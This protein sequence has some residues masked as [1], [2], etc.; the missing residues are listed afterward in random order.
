[1][2]KV[3]DVK[4]KMDGSLDKI[5]RFG[6]RQ[7][8]ELRQGGL[9][10]LRY[11]IALIFS[12]LGVAPLVPLVIALRPWVRIRFGELFS[13]RIGHFACNTE[14]YLCERDAGLHG[15]KT[16]D[17]FCH[18]HSISNQQLKRMWERTLQV[19]S[20]ARPLIKLFLILQQLAPKLQ[21][22]VIFIDSDRDINAFFSKTPPHLF[23]TLEEE[24]EGQRA[25]R[26]MGIPE[27]APFVCFH[28]RDSAYLEAIYPDFDTSYHDYRNSRIQ[29]L[30]PAMEELTRRGYYIVRMGVIV[31]ET[32]NTTNPMIIDYAN[33]YRSDFLDIYLGAKCRFFV[34]ST[35][36]I[37]AIPLIF[38]R[39][40]AVIN[41]IPLEY[42]PPSGAKTLVIPKRLWLRSEERYLTFREI[43]NSGVG[44]FL[45]YDEY[46]AKGIEVIE[47]TPQEITALV[48]EMDEGL[49]GTWQSDAGDE[50]R[51]RRFFSLFR[52]SKLNRILDTRVGAEFL[53]QNHDLLD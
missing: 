19:S 7:V 41:A 10:L 20:L 34:G 35:A 45:R 51:Q 15:K 49:K 21:G 39:P 24:K 14:L 48:M 22:H 28:A 8:K 32:L 25:M 23:F 50:E 2:L 53:R 30:L 38:R 6:R 3:E 36:G 37:S 12:L 46:L 33:K 29:N 31:K 18:S 27:G 9:P 42:F 1:M 47:N 16:W 40:V 43:L 4:D 13:H 44:R 26:Q 5:A 52:N 17:L 11:K